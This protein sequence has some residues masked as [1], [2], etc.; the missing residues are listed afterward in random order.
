MQQDHRSR[1]WWAALAVWTA[2]VLGFSGDGFSAEST[3]RVLEPVLRWLLPGLSG[4]A[5]HFLLL[6][7]RKGAHVFEYAVLAGLAHRALA[8]PPAWW[9]SA[10]FA[11]ALVIAVAVVD[12]T[13]Q[14]FAANRTGTIRDVYV[15]A[16]GGMVGLLVLAGLR[17]R[18]E[19]KRLQREAAG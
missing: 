17:K 3:T 19:A 11:M 9:R 18:R 5:H 14:F 12:E 10:G 7:V 8:E 2:V 4:E 15:D 13:R 16:L 6:L 1:Q